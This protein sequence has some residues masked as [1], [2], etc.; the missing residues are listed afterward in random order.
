MG[1]RNHIVDAHQ[2]FWKYDSVTHGWITDEMAVLRK[3]FTP[4]HLQKT[5]KKNKVDYCVYV[6][7]E[8]NSGHTQQMIDTV[9][10][11][12][13]VKGVVGWVDF[14]AAATEQRLSEFANVPLVKGFRHIVQGESD[15]LF[16]LDKHFNGGIALLKKYDFSYDILVYPHQLPA[17]LEFIDQHPQ[18]KFVIDHLAKPYIKLG[19]YKGWAIMIRAISERENV[20]C[21]LSGMVTEADFQN[22]NAAQMLPYMDF[23]LET[24]GAD[25]LIFG[26]DW[27]VCLVAA[28]YMKVKDLVMGFIKK[29]S[30]QE[31]NKI[32]GLNA[33]QFYK[34]EI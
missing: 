19:Y 10:A 33:M 9:Q 6:Q 15:P 3:D 24:F 16:L 26:S 31:Q 32:M 13:F 12:D 11:Y 29:L 5:L 28:S 17:V 2:H 27:P 1:A 4:A 25:R 7:A 30:S 23:V 21:K 34:L 8:Q 14:R 22:W 20:Y 18:Q